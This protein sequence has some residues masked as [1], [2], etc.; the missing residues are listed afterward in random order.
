ML[1]PFAL[2]LQT[3]PAPTLVTVEK[4]P[5]ERAGELLLAGRAAAPIVATVR[6]RPIGPGVPGLIDYELIESARA[7]PGGCLRRRWRASFAGKHPATP[8]NAVFASARPVEEVALA[9]SKRCPAS[10]YSG[11]QLGTSAAQGL[12]IL[13]R[14]R[15]TLTKPGKIEFACKSEVAS[16]LCATAA[17]TRSALRAERVWMITDR[18]EASEL[19]LGTPGQ[20]VTIVRFNPDAPRQMSVLRKIPAPF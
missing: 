16:G 7:V 5:P 3:A 19:W 10:D 14:F 4:L 8:E 15:D 18:G 2:L 6:P 12:V 11:L 1:L 9:E 17:A 13:A 20:V